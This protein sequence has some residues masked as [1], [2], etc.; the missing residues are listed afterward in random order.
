MS[1]KE[2]SRKGSRPAGSSL[3]ISESE[4]RE[5]SSQV[6][7]LVTEYFSEVSTL[8]VFPATSGGKTV[9]KLGTSLPIE[10]EPIDKLLNDCRV[11]IENSR[12]NGHPRFFGYVASPATAPGAYAD[13]IASTLN[14]NVTSWRSGPAATEIERIVVRWLGALVGYAEDS[15]GLLTSGSSMANLT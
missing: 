1:N 10:G 7:Q 4:M 3:D 2:G 6:T 13:L 14:T 8:P 11:I 5:L 12:H 15:H 9:E